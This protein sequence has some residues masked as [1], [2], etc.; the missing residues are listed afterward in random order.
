MGKRGNVPDR[1][2][3]I[4]VNNDAQ[5]VTDNPYGQFHR[6]G[7]PAEGLVELEEDLNRGTTKESEEAEEEHGQG[8]EELHPSPHGARAEVEGKDFLHVAEGVPGQ[9]S[10]S[11]H[12]G[13]GQGKDHGNRHTHEGRHQ[14]GGVEVIDIL[15]KHSR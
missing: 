2:T 13:L 4:W 6:D 1:P 7:A 5:K 10:L 8:H 3:D 9:G 14:Q 12:D 15:W 11:P